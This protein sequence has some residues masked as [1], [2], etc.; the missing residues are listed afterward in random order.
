[1]VVI[2]S[3]CIGLDFLLSRLRE[4]GFV[5]KFL[6]VGSTAGLEAAKRGEC[7]LAGIHLLDPATDEY[8]APFLSP[9][10]ELIRGYGR[11]Q[12]V[13]FRPGD[14]RFEG[15]SV[16]DAVASAL[17]DSS[18]VLVNRNRGSGTRILI[19]QLLRGSKPPGFLT[20]AKSHQAVAAAIAQGRAD[21][22]VAILPSAREFGLGFLPLRDE[23]YDFVVPKSRMNRPAVNAFRELLA[24]SIIR[25]EL[26]AM[27]FIVN[28]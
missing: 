14:L 1:L 9:E 23:R 15:K 20:E 6:A 26:N 2:G 21:W 17:A 4:R 13:V 24:D 22:G 19:D 16:T 28:T 18:C 10:Q 12:G 27:K 7:D 8:N 11:A 25:R 3:H 5:S